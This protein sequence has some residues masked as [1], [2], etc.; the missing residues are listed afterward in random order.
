[1]KKIIYICLLIVVILGIV[2]FFV[3]Q[4]NIKKDNTN[5]V[6][7]VVGMRSSNENTVN[8]VENTKTVNDGKTKITKLDDG[9][10]YSLVEKQE[11]ADVI[12]GDNY[13]DTQIN[14][15]MLNYKEYKG[16]T[17]EIE[18]MYIDVYA[19]YT[20]VGRYSTSNLCAY[21]PVGYSAF[22]YI[23]NGEKIDMKNEDTWLKII[24]KFAVGND[25][26]SSFQDYYYI[27]AT[28]IEV[29]NE[30]GLKTVSN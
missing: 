30:S 17:V 6:E 24:G 2:L 25:E 7:Q 4:Q 19:P 15:I 12:I 26:T 9:T 23:W 3:F 22:E 8:E 16:K 5:T 10:L 1:M 11:K 28:S 29:M 14:D 13:F 18:G 27:E 20:V 21:C